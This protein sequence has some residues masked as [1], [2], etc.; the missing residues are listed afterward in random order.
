MPL[1]PVMNGTDGDCIFGFR[2]RLIA[3]AKLAAVSVSP[4]F[5]F[6]PGLIVNT[7]VLPSF[8]TDGK[9]TAASGASCPPAGSG[10]S[11]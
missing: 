5:D 2:S 10:L 6:W 7:Y 3:A 4:V 8:E 1:S 9:P 11:G